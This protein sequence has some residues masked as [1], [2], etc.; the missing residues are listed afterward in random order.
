MGVRAFYSLSHSSFLSPSPPSGSLDMTEI[1][2][3]WTLKQW[4]GDMSQCPARIQVVMCAHRRLLS[5][6]SSV[7]SVS[8]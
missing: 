8:L 3:T 4:Y 6:C 7:Q 5:G 2:L 1:L